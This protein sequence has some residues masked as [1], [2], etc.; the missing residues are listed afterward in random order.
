MFII[1]RKSIPKRPGATGSVKCSE[2][3][4]DEENSEECFKRKQAELK[5]NT[6]STLLTK[7]GIFEKKSFQIS[8]CYTFQ[9]NMFFIT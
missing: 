5:V 1:N 2:K 3:S 7:M 9:N 4:P 8:V 6:A